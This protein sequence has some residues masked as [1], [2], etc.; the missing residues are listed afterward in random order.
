MITMAVGSSAALIAAC[1]SVAVDK[2]GSNASASGTGAGGASVASSSS[3]G[4]DTGLG[5]FSAASTGQGG[6]GG[7]PSMPG[8]FDCA[9]CL[10]DG[11]THYCITHDGPKA[12]GPPPPEP[13]CP[14]DGGPLNCM[15]LSIECL[16]KPTCQCVAAKM[17]ACQCDVLPQGISVHCVIP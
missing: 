8:L 10:C 12:P 1:S 17:G 15:P 4:G 11:A 9:G 3:G 7:S 2:S 16:S 13:T 5:G 6:A 14:E